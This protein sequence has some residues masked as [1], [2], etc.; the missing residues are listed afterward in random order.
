MRKLAAIMFT[1][2]EGFTKLMRQNEAE[3]MRMLERHKQ[4]YLQHVKQF[5]GHSIKF[6]G[7]GTLTIFSSVIQAV[8]C[9][10]ALQQALQKEPVIPVRIGIHQGDVIIE[11][12]DVLG[13]AVNFASRI[14]SC[15]IGGSILISEKVNDELQNHD[16]ISTTALGSFDLKNISQTVNLYAIKA[17]GLK[18]PHVHPVTRKEKQHEPTGK[19]PRQKKP[20]VLKKSH[21]LQIALLTIAVGLLCFW[22]I[23]KSNGSNTDALLKTIAV[24]PFKNIDKDEQNEILADGLTEEMISLLSS[25]FELTIK[26]IPAHAINSN[27]GNLQKLL[28][29]INAG[30]MLEGKVQHDKDSLFI[31]VK[32][33]NISTSQLIWSNT[34]REKFRNLMAVQEQVAIKI[35]TELNTSFNKNDVKNFVLDRTSNTDAYLLYIQGRYALRKRT[36]Q[37]M[38]EAILLFNQAIKEDSNF[39]LAYSGISDA[40]TLLVDNGYISHDSGVNLARTAVD[41]AFKLDSSAAEIRASKAIFL[42]TLEGNHQDALKELKLALSFSPNYA[43]AHQWYALELAADGS[44]DSAI[45]HI[46]K[47]VTLEPFSERIWANK[48]LILK[49]ARQYK[50]AVKVLNYSIAH[51]TDNSQLF[52]D[53]KTECHYWLNQKDSVLAYAA[54]GSSGVNGRRFWQAVCNNDVQQLQNLLKDQRNSSEPP[55]TETCA[56]FYVFMRQNDKAVACIKQAYDEKDFSWLLYLNVAPVWDPL[57]SEPIFRN[58]IANMGLN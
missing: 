25:N 42:S 57:H 19:P 54:Y 11:N 56:L 26:K 7:D 18:V 6:L 53:Y 24:I 22:F 9:A 39:A 3:A 1:D 32:L 33:W 15:G 31:F 45:Y 30:C 17:H 51:F 37:S 2:I 47:A 10:I 29:E 41:H 27:S 38:Q 12:K 50:Q 46:N 44:F 8:E 55:D 21:V 20:A 48:G 23:S 36:M 43:D 28:H 52:Y 34:Y 40:Y 5:K 14:Q 13:D 58:I 16:H 35:A 4:L 49:F